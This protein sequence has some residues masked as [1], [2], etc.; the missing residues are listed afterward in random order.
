MHVSIYLHMYIPQTEFTQR[1]SYVSVTSVSVQRPP[2]NAVGKSCRYLQ[3]FVA[4]GCVS[5]RRK[6]RSHHFVL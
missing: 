2:I 1:G 6:A 4:L 5:S 3:H